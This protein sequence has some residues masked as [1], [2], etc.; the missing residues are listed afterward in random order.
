MGITNVKEAA[1]YLG[2]SEDEIFIFSKYS[3]KDWSYKNKNNHAHLF[4]F[5]N[6][7]WVELTKNVEAI[8]V[9]S[10]FNNDWKY[11]DKNNYCHLFREIDGEWIELTKDIKAID[12]YSYI[13]GDWEYKD[14]NRYWHLFTEI[15]N[16]WIGITDE[17]EK[18]LR[19]LNIDP[20]SIKNWKHK[21]IFGDIYLFGENNKLIKKINYYEQYYKQER[22]WQI[23]KNNITNKEEASKFLGIKENEILNFW[24]Y[25]NNGDWSYKDKKGYEH[26]FRR[27]GNQW[28]ELSKE[29]NTT[30]VYSFGDGDW[31]YKDKEGYQHLFRFINNRWVE[32][33]KGI[34]TEYVFSYSNGDW[35]YTD[36]NYNWYK[37][38][39]NNELIEK[40]EPWKQ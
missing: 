2:I 24:K 3:N 31:M 38:N 33:T 5:I 25:H 15:D 40:Y 21:N 36:D 32:L 16:E 11:Y 19:Y 37:F 26:L 6:N 9:F 1:K 18:E 23:F 27:S 29:I 4:R 17:I 30:F 39:K 14:V 12:L 7:Q 20:F 22:N 13:N 8:G 34:K 35:E 10:F 28:I